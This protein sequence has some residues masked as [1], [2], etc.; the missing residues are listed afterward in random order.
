LKSGFNLFRSAVFLFFGTISTPAFSQDTNDC[1]RW[2]T[3]KTD[4]VT[5]KDTRVSRDAL[6]VSADGGKT[7]L[8]I[9]S[10]LNSTGKVIIV[11]IQAMGAGKC[12]DKGDKINILFLDGSKLDL[13]NTNDF[14]CD[15]S[16]TLYF[17]G[18]LGRHDELN[19]LLANR[20]KTMR[21]WTRDDYMQVD[22]KEADA[23]AFSRT[24]ECLASSII[25]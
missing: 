21:V 1:Q 13:T 9:Y 19:L 8:S 15:G 7:G 12:V 11:S 17:G 18:G 24:L 4:S 16:S 10:F 14:N 20:I 5:G 22:F 25:H 2:T 6:L 3:V 23:T